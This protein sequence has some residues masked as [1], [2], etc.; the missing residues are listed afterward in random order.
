MTRSRRSTNGNA[1]N[2]QI[3]ES[4]NNQRSAMRMSDLHLHRIRTGVD[5]HHLL[6]QQ[7]LL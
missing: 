6:P 2:A 4:N 3:K 1:Q 7:G 5:V